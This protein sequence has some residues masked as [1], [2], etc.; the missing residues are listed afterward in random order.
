M[1]FRM[2]ACSTWS[3]TAHRFRLAAATRLLALLLLRPNEPV[4]VDRLVDELWGERPPP[5]AAKNVQVYVCTCE[6]LGD[7]VIA[8]TPSGYAI[9]VP[10]GTRRRPGSAGAGGGGR[11]ACTGAPGAPRDGARR[12]RGPPLAVPRTSRLH[13]VRSGG[14]RSYGCSSSRAGWRPTSSSAGRLEVLVELERLVA[15]H[16]LDERLRA[17]LM[18]ALYRSGRQADALEVYRDARRAL[19]QELGLEPDEE[20]RSLEQRILA[21]DPSLQARPTPTEPPRTSVAGRH[22]RGAPRVALL[23]AALL[24]AAAL[25]G[26]VLAISR[27]DSPARWACRATDR[28]D[29]S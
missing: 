5:T 6:A 3:P 28:R 10:D 23:G 7:D 22:R 24:V 15:A 27:D 17:Q 4:S 18:L 14:S 20:L 13:K 8:T 2:S 16:P 19:T 9:C 1:E 26:V 29:R 11:P 12:L 21:H 25:L